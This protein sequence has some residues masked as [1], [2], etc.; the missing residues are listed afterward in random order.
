M[1]NKEDEEVV[2]KVDKEE[3]EADKTPSKSKKRK[4]KKKKNSVS[5]VDGDADVGETTAPAA[6]PSQPAEPSQ[7]PDSPPQLTGEALNAALIQQLEFYFSKENL[8]QDAYLV[9]QMDAQQFVPVSII[10]NFKRVMALST[11]SK[12]V[13]EA[14][15]QCSNIKLNA[16]ETMVA[17]NLKSKRN[18]L[19]L[20]DI[21]A[22][23]PEEEIRGIFSAEGCA[24]VVSVK[25][26]VGDTWFVAFETEEDCLDTCLVLTNQTFKGKPVR[27]RVKSENV[28]RSFF[29]ANGKNS[30]PTAAAGY[31]GY[32]MQ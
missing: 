18:T 7:I 28:V 16:E 5:V 3:E 4:N 1:S 17:P 30:S 20:R 29:Y 10:A 15:K 21:P 2:N 27:A 25:A 14:M 12:V 9:S 26:D 11:D 31:G 32:G 19:I 8:A 23:T 6:S 24:S 13:V 22:D